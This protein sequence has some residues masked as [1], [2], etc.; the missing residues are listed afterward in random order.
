MEGIASEHRFDFRVIL[1][2]DGIIKYQKIRQ[3]VF[4]PA[5]SYDPVKLE[6]RAY[7]C[8]N[9]IIESILAEKEFQSAFFED[10]KR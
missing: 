6:T 9:A 1:I 5:E 3:L 10:V 2:K 7:G 4:K 8:V